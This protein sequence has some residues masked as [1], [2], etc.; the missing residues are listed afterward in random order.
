MMD[1]KAIAQMLLQNPGALPQQKG[2]NNSLMNMPV[3]RQMPGNMQTGWPA[4][5]VPGQQPG[6]LPNLGQL[7]GR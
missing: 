6:Q 7:L 5:Q 4:R 3:R 1:M 2:G